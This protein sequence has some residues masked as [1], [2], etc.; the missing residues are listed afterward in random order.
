MSAQGGV[1]AGFVQEV[2]ARKGCVMVEYRAIEDQMLSPWAYV[3]APLAGSKRGMLFMPE[4]GDEVL[5][6]Y[7]DNDFD[8][9]YVVGYLWNGE[10]LSP[11]TEPKFRVIKTPGGHEL[12]FEDKDNA[13]KVVL[14][15]EG[16]RSVTLDDAPGKGQVQVKS[17]ANE[18]LMDDTAAGTQVRLQAG[19][20]VGVTI[21]MTATPTPSLSISVGA[22]ATL[23]IDSTGVSLNTTGPLN[24]T[25]ASAANITCTSANLTASAAATVTAPVLSVNSAMATFTGVVQCTSLIAST[26]VVSPMYTPGVGNLL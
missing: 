19:Q 4:V 10:H 24:V 13:K 22:G 1:V 23:S 15:S 17:G 3:A 5:V 7:A 9:P 20:G 21:T 12:R 16:G 6:C 26:S 8:H 14:K 2:D 18:I 11:E 25:T